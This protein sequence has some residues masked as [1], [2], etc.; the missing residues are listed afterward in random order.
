M[1]PRDFRKIHTTM[2]DERITKGFYYLY[3]WFCSLC[4]G[5]ISFCT[6]FI[7]RK[8]CRFLLCFRLALLHSVPYFFFLYQS[9]SLSLCT[10]FDF[11]S[12]NI[13]DVL[14]INPSVNKFPFGDFNIHHKDWLTNSGETDRSG[15]LCYY[16]SISKGYSDLRL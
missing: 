1:A 8:L 9:P 6:G 10:V 4:E 12:S 15:E 7:S 2:K 5:G 13:D 16:F 11:N 3:A 14:S